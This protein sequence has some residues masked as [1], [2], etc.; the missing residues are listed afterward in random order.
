[1]KSYNA[2]RY[3]TF[4]ITKRYRTS[5]KWDA[6]IEASI[7]TN[8][9][10][11]FVGLPSEY[12]EFKHIENLYYIETKDLYEA[13]L[14]AVNNMCNA[15]FCNQSALLT[16]AQGCN[17]LVYLEQHTRHKTAYIDR[18]KEILLTNEMF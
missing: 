14:I 9:F 10:A 5:I 18:E 6:I 2:K 15:L 1:M 17:Q 13:A 8:G 16:I 12:E 3:D 7:N 4:N 11:W